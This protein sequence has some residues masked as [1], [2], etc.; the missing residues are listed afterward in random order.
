MNKSVFLA[1]I[2]IAKQLMMKQIYSVNL[3]KKSM[4]ELS[5]NQSNL[6]EK[7]AVLQIASEQ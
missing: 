2:K 6:P 3:L 1:I 7:E 4:K 5:G